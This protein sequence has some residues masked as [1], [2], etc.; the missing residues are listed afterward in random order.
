[1]ARASTHTLLP[2][3]TA[4]RLTG[5]SPPHFNQMAGASIFPAQGSCSRVWF[6]YDWQSADQISREGFAD[7]IRDA[8]DEIA[9]LIRYYPAPRWISSEMHKFP[10]FY[11]NEFF[12]NGRNVRGMRKSVIAKFGKFIRAG[13]RAVAL[14]GTP[15]VVYSDP[16]G[17]GFDE[18]ATVTQATALTDECEINVYF[19]G[20]GGAQEWEIRP[21]KT[22]AITGGNFVATFD[23]WLFGDPDDWE[24]FPTADS[25]VAI[26]LDS[27]NFVTT[28]D[29]YREFTDFAQASAE[30]SW[31]PSPLNTLF[32]GGA[33][34]S[35]CGGTGCIACENSI[36]TGCLHTR[37]VDRGVIVPQPATYDADAGQWNKVQF[38]ICREPD[39][40]KVWYYAG[41]LDNKFLQGASCERLS[42]WF[43]QAIVW[44]AVSRL[45]RP[46]CACNNVHKHFEYLRQ[47]LARL[48]SGELNDPSFLLSENHLDN[49]FGTK[50]GEIKAW[51]RIGRLTEEMGDFALV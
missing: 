18:L 38:S 30:F 47:D 22:K 45:D 9:S 7:T 51:D 33:C 43:A 16:D 44:L 32:S 35:S 24:A 15:D 4:A 21:A 1:M 40:V 48:G 8:E 12:G 11:R 13:R 36:Q 23:S 39:T 42:H 6:Q 31:E 25:A 37:D 2:L 28:A 26:V 27:A 50:R 34:C 29:V 19:A 41:D 46:P 17:D 20:E 5:I 3:D 10:A 14:Q 49:P